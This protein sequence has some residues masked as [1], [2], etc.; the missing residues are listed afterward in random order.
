M[1][2]ELV[3]KDQEKTEQ[4]QKNVI[5]LEN[6][7]ETHYN[8]LDLKTKKDG[9]IFPSLTNLSKIVKG[10]SNIKGCFKYNL[11]TYEIEIAK[12][13]TIGDFSFE[14]NQQIDD[15]L[16]NSIRF[17]ISQKYDVDFKKNDVSDYLELSAKIQ[18]YN[19]LKEWLVDAESGYKGSD[20][21][22][23]L[24]NYL[25]V[26]DDEYTKL[27]TYVFFRGAIAKVMNPKQK[28]DSVLDLVGDQG[29]GKSTLINLLFDPYYTDNIRTFYKTDDMALM[30]K[31]WAVNDDEMCASNDKNTTFGQ[32]KKII[33]QQEFQY[34]PPYAR[35][36]IQADKN[37][38]ITRTTNK[39]EH[40]RDAT[41]DRRFL[42]IRVSKKIEPPKRFKELDEDALKEF[43]GG[44]VKLWRENKSFDLTDE[45]QDLL[46]AGKES[47]KSKSFFVEQ[48]E[49]YINIPITI[50]F[51]NRKAFERKSY[52]QQ[53]MDTGQAFYNDKELT[54][55]VERDRVSVADVITELFPDE[56]PTTVDNI[57]RLFFNNLD[58]WDKKPC[59][60]FGK[61]STSGYQRDKAQ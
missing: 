29:T 57:I 6:E 39:S 47:F 2:K 56:K 42:P 61:R 32:L 34:R 30:I 15:S 43:W 53:M 58:D 31:N 11:F 27:V 9:T 17:Y 60:K 48:L 55:S 37:F 44:M 18:S 50:D 45:Q 4:A 51:Y 28:F 38:V 26:V 46:D 24:P 10:D 20:P 36:N 35:K 12:A 54:G 49:E 5:N 3:A 7:K 59:I 14:P 22:K 25:G 1:L 33:T 23:I 41:G 8:S 21:L 52:I 16:I 13:G 40:L 19:P